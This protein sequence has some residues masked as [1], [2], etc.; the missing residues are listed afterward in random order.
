ML[1]YMF[2]PHLKVSS[3]STL[4][5]TF[6]IKVE[7]VNERTEV[8]CSVLSHDVTAAPSTSCWFQIQIQS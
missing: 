4:D 8:N 5:N 1:E 7:S 6:S 3:L 2:R